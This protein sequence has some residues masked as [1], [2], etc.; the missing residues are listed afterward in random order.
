[1]YESSTK[2]LVI[3]REIKQLSKIAKP[4]LSDQ[5]KSSEKITPVE[6]I[7][8]LH[9]MLNMQNFRTPFSQT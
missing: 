3:S 4:L 7:K 9:E 6:G 8:F 2:V 1:M 5:T